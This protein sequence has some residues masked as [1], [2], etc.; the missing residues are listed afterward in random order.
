MPGKS[1]RE[2]G[3]DLVFADP[4]AGVFVGGAGLLGV[5][6]GHGEAAKPE[7][8]DGGIVERRE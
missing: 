4:I 3:A 6:P 1:L 5:E 2:G 8:L 7:A